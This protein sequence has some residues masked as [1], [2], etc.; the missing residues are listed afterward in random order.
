VGE[1]FQRLLRVAREEMGLESLVLGGEGEPG[2]ETLLDA[3]ARGAVA[4]AEAGFARGFA[5][6]KDA[7]STSAAF[8]HEGVSFAD[9]AAEADLSALLKRVLPKA[10]RRAEGVRAVLRA[11]KPKAL[12][13][14][15]DDALVLRAARVEGTPVLPFA[16]ARDGPRMLLALERAARGAGM[17]G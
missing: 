17:V 2:P 5:E 1:A 3:P 6:L 15:A 10:V 7:P 11:R 13:A 4:E 16:E 12:C 14:A 9:L 8:R